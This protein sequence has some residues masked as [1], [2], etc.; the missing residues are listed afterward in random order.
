MNTIAETRPRFG[1]V[2]PCSV[3]LRQIPD[4]PPGEVGRYQEQQ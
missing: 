2:H 3:V 1:P 4:S